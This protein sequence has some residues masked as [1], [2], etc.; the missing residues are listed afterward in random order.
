[1]KNNTFRL[2]V[3]STFSDFVD[4]RNLLHDEVLPRVRAFCNQHGYEFQM[5]DL[6]WGIH[7][8]S[9]LNHKTLPICLDEVKRCKDYSPCPS[10]LAMIGE[11]YGWIPLPPFIVEQEFQDILNHLDK[12]DRATLSEWYIF[13]ANEQD[14]GYYL[15][16]RTDSF[17]DESA[18]E[19]KEA[20]LRALLIKGA[21]NAGFSEQELI[22]YTASATEHEIINGFLGEG[23]LADNAIVFI[24]NGFAVADTDKSM[25][26]ALKDRVTDQMVKNDNLSRMLVLD[27]NEGDYAEIFVERITQLLSDAILAEINRLEKIEENTDERLR[28]A[29]YYNDD[30]VYYGYGDAYR[31]I[32]DYVNGNSSN[33]LFVS[34][35]SGTGKTTLLAKFIQEYGGKCSFAF[36]GESPWACSIFDTVEHLADD[37]LAE[38]KI[39]RKER[40]DRKSLTEVLSDAISRI[41]KHFN[42]HLIV[43][44]GFDMFGDLAL[45]K[46]DFL[47]ASLPKNVKMIISYADEAAVERFLSNKG[48]KLLL[49]DMT[50]EESRECFDSFMRRSHRCLGDES[51]RRMV[52]DVIKHGG[53]P[54]R[55]KLLAGIA[56][57]WVSGRVIDD[58]P[59]TP[60]ET[61]LKY[62]NSSYEDFGHDKEFVLY[63]LA[64]ISVAPF[65]LSEDDILSMMMKFDVVEANFY[66]ESKH[67]KKFNGVPF[68][69]WSRLFYD[70]DE[71]FDMSYSDG[72]FLIKFT[73][74]VFPTVVIKEFSDYCDKARRILFDYAKTHIRERARYARIVLTML[75]EDGKS[76]ELAA[77]I[78]DPQFVN[79]Y[80]SRGGLVHLSELLSS[81]LLSDINS[82]LQ[83]KAL[84]LIGCLNDYWQMLKRYKNTFYI[85]AYER[86]IIDLGEPVLYER[87]A[88]D[89]VTS[90]RK[91][92]AFH[93]STSS[94]LSWNNYADMYAVSDGDDVYICHSESHREIATIFVDDRS[95]EKCEIMETVWLSEDLL[96]VITY[97]NKMLIYKIKT[98]IPSLLY[99][100][101][102][103]S[104]NP[105]VTF[106]RESELLIYC[107]ND[108]IVCINA[109]SGC[110]VYKI[111]IKMNT[112]VC[113]NQ[114]GE[115]V[116]YSHMGS[117]SIKYAVYD[118]RTGR[119]IRTP[120]INSAAR[121]S[122]PTDTNRAFSVAGN[123]ILQILTEKGKAGFFLY[124]FKNGAYSYLHPPMYTEIIQNIVSENFLVSVYKNGLFAIDFNERIAKYL[125]INEIT[126]AAWI[127]PDHS[128]AVLTRNHELIEVNM[129]DFITDANKAFS[130]SKNLFYGSIKTVFG[131][132]GS[133]FG[134]LFARLPVGASSDYR[135]AFS[136][137]YLEH[138]NKESE[139]REDIPTLVTVASDGKRAIAYEYADFVSVQDASGEM[140]F[141]I[142]NL[143]LGFDNNLLRL[144]FSQDS[145]YLII[146]TNNFL[147]VVSIR[148]AKL[149]RKISLSKRPLIDVTIKDSCVIEMLLSD[150]KVYSDNL[151]RKGILRPWLP[152][153]VAN[154]DCTSD[155][156]FAYYRNPL[157]DERPHYNVIDTV[158]TDMERPVSEWFS[159]VRAYFGKS[160][161]LLYRNGQFYIN[162][163]PDAFFINRD[164]YDFGGSVNDSVSTNSSSFETYI[165]QKNDISSSLYEYDGGKYLLLV[166]KMLNSVVL[167]DTFSRRILAAHKHG[168]KIIGSSLNER[169]DLLTLFLDSGNKTK[170]LAVNIPKEEN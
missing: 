122:M 159:D 115:L 42:R 64:L 73:H 114:S 128:I 65:G 149:V 153:K 89:D 66:K 154:Y 82:D 1:M 78:T 86:N 148:E 136:S 130:D 93:Y 2:F 90:Q 74:N 48:E 164:K 123:R 77:V 83:E 151:G 98:D 76:D 160:K 63:C 103:D 32:E 165:S 54:L 147:Q 69:I 44:D 99:T 17:V 43:I 36:Y 111:P 116:T 112:S 85:C 40:Y 46:E 124:N 100:L 126:T 105:F 162:G 25:I 71:C 125:P 60:F 118:S 155:Y 62:I 29:P 94:R 87:T 137:F 170:T 106:N 96:S 5:I 26:N 9:T 139:L 142:D 57:K 91:A 145:N 169:G 131:H 11:R 117:V 30:S 102:I 107:E 80:I 127:N 97:Q 133:I 166:C 3:S 33:I 12:I 67:E 141:V 135:N 168:G 38:Y 8:E 50:A 140:L 119:I 24:R 13:D 158:Y 59:S 129:S 19:N 58:I 109:E 34:G 56:S 84:R 55:M 146:W 21:T 75:L 51:Q 121:S 49:A 18:W 15:K 150:G 167:F 6:R 79:Y 81:V 92:S 88:K 53:S 10:F 152:I 35:S 31:A 108:N 16:S 161:W 39:Y 22:K 110:D 72:E 41:P 14:G 47:P 132:L 156:K 68:V 101:S 104:Q 4:E 61:A 45:L 134:D 23:D 113:I 95:S 7:T 27:Y 143:S 37:I 70:L 120:V 157:E 163:D 20:E 52:D 144:A 28:L 138:E